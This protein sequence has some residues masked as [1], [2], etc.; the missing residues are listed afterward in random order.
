[1]SCRFA[2]AFMCC[3]VAACGTSNDKFTD[4][5]TDA[6]NSDAPF[7]PDSFVLGGDS[8]GDSGNCTQCSADLHSILTCLLV[9]SDSNVSIR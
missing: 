3:V 6:T 4:G 5:G 1:M 8:G 7:S 2:F 9:R